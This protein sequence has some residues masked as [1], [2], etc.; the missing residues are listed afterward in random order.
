M[1]Q[2]RFYVHV[3]SFVIA[4][5]FFLVWKQFNLMFSVY[6]SCYLSEYSAV[7]IML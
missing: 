3:S 6:N 7:I 1:E 4:L 2:N 5:F